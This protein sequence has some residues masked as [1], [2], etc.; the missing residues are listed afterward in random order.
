MSDYAQQDL[1]VATQR[2]RILDM[3]RLQVKE[4]TQA[5]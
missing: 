3:Q 5:Y 1:F 4:W 2:P